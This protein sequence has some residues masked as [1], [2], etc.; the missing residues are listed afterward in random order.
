M[1]DILN[2]D[3]VNFTDIADI[4]GSAE[5]ILAR[6]SKP[7]QFKTTC[8]TQAKKWLLRA[9]TVLD[10]MSCGDAMTVTG[11]YEPLHLI[12]FNQAASA[13]KLDK[14]RLDAFESYIRG[15]KTVDQ[16]ALRHT[17]S[18]EIDRRNPKYFGRPLQWESVCIDRWHKQF[19][20]GASLDELSDYDTLNRVSTLLTTDLW[21]F[22]T[23]NESRY[24]QT[25]FENHR[26]YLDSIHNTQSVMCYSPTC[27][28]P[29][30]P[31][32]ECGVNEVSTYQRPATQQPD[33]ALCIMHYELTK[34]LSSLLISGVPFLTQEEYTAYD[35]RIRS[36]LIASKETN[37]YLKA[38]LRINTSK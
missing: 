29:P 30:D 38:A 18:R 24:K 10:S 4:A 36:A 7:G 33:N 19:R 12:A 35:T 8:K 3:E 25:L 22:E 6:Y 17:I 31:N 5:L 32:L 1:Y 2:I 21:S 28:T 15:D 37:R 20:Y 27:A 14:Y 26:H 9:D 13:A 11:Y 34:A 23:R 16:Y